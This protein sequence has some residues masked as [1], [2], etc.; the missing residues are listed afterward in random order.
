[1]NE[2]LITIFI[3]LV[4][5]AATVVP[6]VRRLR[7]KEGKARE[8]FQQLK[9]SGLHEASAMHPQ[10]DAL[11]CIGCAACVRACPEGDVLGIIEGKATLIHGAK[12]V[13]HGLCAEACPVGAINLLM[14]KPGR[15]ADLPMI[16]ERYESSVK[17]MYIVGELG[18]LGLIK[19][20]I[21]QGT[22]VVRH[23]TSLPH[24]TD[25]DTYDVAII[26]AGPAGFAAGLTALENNLRYVILEQNDIG[27]TVLQYPR[28]KIVMTSP[29]ELPLWGKVKLIETRKE[30]LLELWQAVIKKTG[31]KIHTGVKVENIQHDENQFVIQS[32]S[33]EWKAKYVVL[34]L[35]RRGTP[36]KLGVAGEQLSK[37]TY[38]LI[39]AASY[40]NS[41]VLVVGGGD[42][43][44]E[45]A[46]GLASQKGNTVSL[47]YR[48]N[49][50]S[51]IKERNKAHIDDFVSRKK[52]I[53]E[54]NSE[55]KEIM[56]EKVM[57]QTPYGVSEI[58][59]DF[60]FIFAGGE[61]PNEFLKKIGIQMQVQVME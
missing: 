56:E 31:I 50:F 57:L 40:Q 6:Y 30:A 61:L 38:R 23:I 17:G 35:G 25:D 10:I 29:V 55:V 53:V 15:S 14:A 27:G 33:G 47:S 3:T 54:F 2:T 34:A 13:G 24:S 52:I 59:N 22:N 45:A 58:P 46:I 49:E 60:V 32:A 20:A 7:K 44:I 36:R 11:Q 1:M 51:R 28:A 42:S 43:A 18:G 5:V 9:I 8:K 21:T 12:C 48:K 4:L 19:N 39:D 16:D 41:H 26:G 37:V